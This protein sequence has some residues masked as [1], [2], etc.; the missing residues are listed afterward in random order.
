MRI[1][2]WSS[3]V[4]SSDLAV[5]PGI[6]VADEHAVEDHAGGLALFR[7]VQLRLRAC[8]HALSRAGLAVRERA[9]AE[10]DTAAVGR[11]LYT[12]D[13]DRERGELHRLAARGRHR[14][15]LR[16]IILRAVE[17]HRGPVRPERR[18]GEIGTAHVRNPVT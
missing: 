11:A 10:R 15:Q 7:S 1:S 6:P 17:V 18:R 2:D 4:C 16:R 13:T 12:V 14:L 5:A 3:D 8:E 9:R